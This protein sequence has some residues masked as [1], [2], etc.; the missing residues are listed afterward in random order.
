MTSES[1]HTYLKT[2]QLQTEHM[3]LSLEDATAEMIAKSGEWRQRSAITLVKENGLSV[4]L[5]HLH[6][7]ASLEE[8]S[9]EGPTIVQVLSGHVR[10]QVGEES[11]DAPA[12]RLVSFDGGI[13]HSVTADRPSVLLIT[14]ATKA[15]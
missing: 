8:H 7:G 13:R 2:H 5:T 3:D 9:A 1:G 6:E 12:G 14:L 11:I 10:M 15:S 4:L